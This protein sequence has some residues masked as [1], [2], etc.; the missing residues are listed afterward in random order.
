MDSIEVSL[1][2]FLSFDILSNGLILS[3]AAKRIKVATCAQ[4]PRDSA[5]AIL[6]VKEANSQK[7]GTYC[8]SIIHSTAM[9]ICDWLIFRLLD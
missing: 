7:G 1:Y 3:T 5:A 8:Q 4:E 6:S 2:S 9:F